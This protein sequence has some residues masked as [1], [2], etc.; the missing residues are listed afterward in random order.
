M[1]VILSDVEVALAAAA[2]GASVV[3][4][5]YGAETTRHAKAGGDFATEAD[6][7][8]ERAIL[9]VIEA[10]RPGDARIGEE[11]GTTGGSGTRRWLVDP[12]CGT[13]NFAAH[14]P[15]AAVNVALVDGSSTL[16]CVSADPIADEVFWTDGQRAL[17]RR[18]GCDQPLRPSAASRLVD[19]NCD[20]PA[21]QPFV[22]PQL[23]ADP[24][25]RAAFGPRV[26]STTLAV[27]WVAAGRRAA[28]ISDGHFTDNVHF[29]AGIGV[30]RNAGCVITDLAGEPLGAGRGLIVAA[31]T[32][33]H[34]RLLEIIRPHLAMTREGTSRT[35]AI[36][37]PDA[38]ARP[39]GFT[40]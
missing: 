3:R 11:T 32:E 20:G 35:N 10:A 15:L 17:L 36:A 7:N 40:A 21:D 24:A 4:A 9:D 30:C 31:D 13:I 16:A 38:F 27:A 39:E 5:A 26:L 2:A 8:A 18:I 33:T 37:A 19:I 28:Y 25:F 22:G 12:L 14:T 29:A 6:L 23:V 1:T 34:G